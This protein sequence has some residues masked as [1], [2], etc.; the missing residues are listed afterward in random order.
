MGCFQGK[1]RIDSINF[2]S[3]TFTQTST[4]GHEDVL[5][6]LNVGFMLRQAAL[7]STPVMIISENDGKWNITTKTSMKSMEISFKL[8]EEFE[9]ETADGRKCK[10]IVTLESNK[11]ITYQKAMKTGQKDVVVV[12]FNYNH[13]YYD[14][15]SFYFQVREF[16]ASGIDYTVTVEGVMSKQ[17]FQRN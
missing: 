12:S 5:K 10:T 9:E 6:A 11:M 4:E 1:V 15:I 13:L 3:G 8:G 7:A 14:P 17:R 16:D 2:I